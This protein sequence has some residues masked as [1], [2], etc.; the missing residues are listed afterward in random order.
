M[1]MASSVQGSRDGT[2]RLGQAFGSGATHRQ[3]DPQTETAPRAGP[4]GHFGALPRHQR[5]ALVACTAW[6]I[7]SY[8]GLALFAAGIDGVLG[9]SHPLPGLLLMVFGAALAVAGFAR[10]RKRIARDGDW[11]A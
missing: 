7:S 2:R 8:C 10:G 3:A 6:L 4:W 11:L 5:R 9:T 1:A